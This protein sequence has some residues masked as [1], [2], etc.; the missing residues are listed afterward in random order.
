MATRFEIYTPIHKGLRRG[1]S[2]LAIKAGKL[3]LNDEI[4]LRALCDEIQTHAG[5]VDVHHTLEERFVHPM[6]NAR[7]PGGAEI[8]EEEHRAVTHHLDNL[9]S[10]AARLREE[11]D[12]KQ[13]QDLGLECYLALNRFI[14]LFWSHLDREEEQAQPTLW[15]FY[16]D[17][18][19]VETWNRL[20]AAQSAA[21]AKANLELI[22]AAS[23]MND[24]VGEF[25]HVD[26]RSLPKDHPNALTVAEQILSADKLSALKS[27]LGFP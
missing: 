18:E 20:L 7:V 11:P 23:N 10:F 17:E 27:Q 3:D 13:R 8:L 5:L 26:V 21:D 16:S 9:T 4:A 12:N 2:L 15:R 1:V 25:R 22:F 6:L 24:I 19:L 14:G